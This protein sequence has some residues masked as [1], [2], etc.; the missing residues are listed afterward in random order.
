M[1]SSRQGASV[2]ERSPPVT[3]LSKISKMVHVR[4]IFSV[5][6]FSLNVDLSY[7]V[8]L[9]GLDVAM[10]TRGTSFGCDLKRASSL[11]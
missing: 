6:H 11:C 3:L 8:S 5:C 10:A 2:N 9:T 7:I 4:A 1:A